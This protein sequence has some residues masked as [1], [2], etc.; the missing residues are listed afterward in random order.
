MITFSLMCTGLSKVS[1][2]LSPKSSSE[3]AVSDFGLSKHLENEMTQTMTGVTL[4]LSRIPS[5]S[6][7][8]RNFV[9]GSTGSIA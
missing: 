7:S 9:L 3:C 8:G 2:T 1:L 6:S 5:H 4:C